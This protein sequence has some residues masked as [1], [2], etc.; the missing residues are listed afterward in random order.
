MTLKDELEKTRAQLRAEKEEWEQEIEKRA[1][2]NLAMLNQRVERLLEP[3]LQ[4]LS[5]IGVEE[6]FREI[7]DELGLKH[8]RQNGS[9]PQVEEPEII[10]GADIRDKASWGVFSDTDDDS[11]WWRIDKS[12]QGVVRGG[13]SDE[14]ERSLKSKIKVKA[15]AV[16]MEWGGE[17][18]WSGGRGTGGDTLVYTCKSLFVGLQKEKK[19]WQLTIGGEPLDLEDQTGKDEIRPAILRAFVKIEDYS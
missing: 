8:R 15:V 5:S 12:G 19:G 14:I 11:F 17:T 9:D 2:K 3:Y 10:W 18:H 4:I 16:K 1:Q 7:I 13:R 6:I